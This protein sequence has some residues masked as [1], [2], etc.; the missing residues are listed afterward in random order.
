M[1]ASM[2]DHRGAVNAIAVSPRTGGEAIS[3]SSDGSCIVWDFSAGGLK[4]RASFQSNTF[5]K[6]VAYHPDESQVWARA[7]HVQVSPLRPRGALSART[8]ALRSSVSGG[9]GRV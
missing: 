6:A 9:R 7:P 4:R 8:C 5:F 1:V 3:A 2:K